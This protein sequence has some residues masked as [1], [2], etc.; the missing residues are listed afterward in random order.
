MPYPDKPVIDFSYQYYLPYGTQL[1]NDLA[2]LVRGIDDTIDALA[3]V[4]RSDGALVNGVVTPDALSAAT[5]ALITGEGATGPTGPS[6]PAGVGATGAT[7]P[8]G[9]AGPAGAA[10]VAGPT[11]ITGA[12]GPAGATGPTGVVGA[13]G[14]TGNAGP[15]GPTGVAGLTG[16]T[17]PTGVTGPTG[18]GATGATGPVGATG[19]TGPTGISVT[20]ATGATGATPVFEPRGRLTLTSGAPIQTVN[21]A[22]ATTIYFTPYKGDSIALWSGSAFVAR[23]FAELSLALDSNA[24]D[25]GYHQSG[26]IMDLL[27]FDDAGTLRLGTGVAWSGDNLIGTGAGSAEREYLNGFWVNKNAMVC[28]F[29]SASGNTV[30]VAARRG[31]IV[32]SVMFT[33]NGQTEFTP[34][35]AGAAGGTPAKLMLSN[36]YNQMQIV[37]VENDTTSSYAKTTTATEAFGA[38]TNNRIDFL[39][40]LADTSVAAEAGST[41]IVTAANATPYLG[42]GLD[43]TSIMTGLKPLVSTAATGS[44]IPA[45]ASYYGI[46]SIGKHSVYALQAQ[47]STTQGNFSG[48]TFYALR[49]ALMV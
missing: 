46:P 49:A 4:R 27:V 19:A 48:A 7:G 26:K 35:P 31:L 10:G 16:A 12:T 22:A 43:S 29:G 8:S 47:F 20:G 39:N 23:S 5:R 32:G 9:A 40:A 6:G 38:S 37:A 17:G 1:D 2:E 28:R 34:A 18:A 41:L 3:D 36:I 13:T 33:A 11:G 30:S 25:T 44:N 24:A 42:I 14:V 15:T 45:L 21:A